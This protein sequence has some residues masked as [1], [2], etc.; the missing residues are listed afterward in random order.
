LRLVVTRSGELYFGRERID[1]AELPEQIRI[2]VRAGAENRV[3][4]LVDGRTRYMNVI[5]VLNEIGQSGVKN[6]R[7]LTRPVPRQNAE[8]QKMAPA[9]TQRKGVSQ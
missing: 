6:I 8:A 3:Y 1:R 4:L 5:P 7:F 2:G 9:P